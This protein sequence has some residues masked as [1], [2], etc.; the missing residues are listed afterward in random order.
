MVEIMEFDFLNN[1]F[2]ISAVLNVSTVEDISI[3]EY[4]I[5][6]DPDITS[7][8]ELN[9]NKPIY[10]EVNYFDPCNLIEKHGEVI[11]LPSNY[12]IDEGKKNMISI[13]DDLIFELPTYSFHDS[14]NLNNCLKAFASTILQENIKEENIKPL[15]GGASGNLVFYITNN[16]KDVVIKTFKKDEVQ[17]EHHKFFMETLSM[18]QV[19]KLDLKSFKS[20]KLLNISFCELENAVYTMNAQEHMS[21]IPIGRYTSNILKYSNESIERKQALDKAINAFKALGEGMAEFHYGNNK[22]T[23]S[24]IHQLYINKFTNEFKTAL[25]KFELFKTSGVDKEKFTNYFYD[26]LERAKYLPFKHGFM[27]LDPNF[28]NYL[29]YENKDGSFL[30]SIIDTAQALSSMSKDQVPIGMPGFDY[31]LIS[32]FYFK[33]EQKRSELLFQNSLKDIEIEEI[34]TAYKQSYIN[35]GGKALTENQANLY[36]LFHSILY[37]N[38]F[39]QE[40]YTVSNVD[41]LENIKDKKKWVAVNNVITRIKQALERYELEEYCPNVY[42]YQLTLQDTRLI[43]D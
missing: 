34:I 12:K 24:A 7:K 16:H 4:E 29:A 10:T 26:L 28:G 41:Q 35:N 19:Y 25:A 43:D 39:L 20:P 13:M 22:G 14:N 38:W 18:I 6:K 11:L 17:N 1:D 36:E 27:H 15:L 5:N 31:F 30:I 21:G 33:M 42:N 9:L 23:F 2:N 8:I 32:D 3:I 40:K 37:V